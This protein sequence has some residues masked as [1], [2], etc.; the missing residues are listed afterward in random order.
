MTARLEDIDFEDLVP[1]INKIDPKQGLST[2]CMAVSCCIEG[3]QDLEI[4][5]ILK[6]MD[7]LNLI[8][9]SAYLED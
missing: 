6:T 1:V 3:I 4:V 2:V 8:N 7:D 9:L 5:E